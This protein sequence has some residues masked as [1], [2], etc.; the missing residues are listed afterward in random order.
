MRQLGIVGLGKMG[1][2]LAMQAHEKKIDVIGKARKSKPELEKQG[3]RVVTDYDSFARHLKQPRVVYL[4]LPAGPTVDT[5]LDELAA[6]LAKGDVVMD[7]GNSFYLDSIEREKRMWEKG[8]YFLDCGTSGG[9]EGARYGACFMVGGR[10]EGVRIAEP[11]LTALS[12]KDGYVHTGQPGSGHFVKLVHNGIEFGMLQ[13]IGEGVELLRKSDF[14]LDL[15]KIFKNWSNGSVIRGWLV[16]LMER[17]LREQGIDKVES[18]VEDTGEVNWLV[19]D[20]VSK[21][22][23]IPIISQAVME[24]FKSRMSESNAYKAIALMRHGFGGHPF[25]KDKDIAEERKTSRVHKV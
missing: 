19:Q 17:G 25:G 4:S 10:Q 24:L 21:E 13:S 12:V 5:V 8:I 1:G 9:L 20:A 23:P 16:E 7:G 11:L 14:R 6:Y 22:I 15:Q 2:N 18:Y 3:I